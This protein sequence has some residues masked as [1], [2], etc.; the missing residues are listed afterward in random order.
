MH[1]TVRYAVV[2]LCV[3]FALSIGASEGHA[4]NDDAQ[5]SDPWVVYD[6]YEG[7]G[8][9]KHIVFV[10]GDEEYRSEEALPQ[11]AKILATRHGFKCTVLFAIDPET[12]TID[13]NTLDNIPGLETLETADL[14]VIFTRFRDLPDDQMEHIAGYL[15]RGGPV[16]GMRTATHAFRF[17]EHDTYDRYSFRSEAEGWTGGF[18]RRT[19]GETWVNHHGNHGEESTRGLPNGLW[20]E[21]PILEGVGRIWGPTDVYGLRDLRGDSLKVLVY[22]QSLKGMAPTASPNADKSI[23]PVAWTRTYQVK[24]GP[25][26]RVFATTM[27]A[28]QD[29]ESEDLRRLLVNASYWATGVEK[30]SSELDVGLV[31]DYD[32]TPFGFDEFKKGV[33]PSDHEL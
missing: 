19:L 15:E 12:G 5:D 11:L 18:G 10:S 33:R 1:Q 2:T 9:G 29:L 17:Q 8:E 30:P 22:G 13:P 16:I 27:G 14:M 20:G 32:P 7:P 31:G 25:R 4:Q 26:G 23:M 24:G 28:S 3:A 21:H 6:G